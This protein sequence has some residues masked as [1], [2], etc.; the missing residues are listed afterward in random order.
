[1]LMNYFLPYEKL[2]PLFAALK[3][4]GYDCIAPQ[5]RDG[6]IVYDEII[7][8]K[9]LP[10]GMRDIQQPGSYQLEA[11]GTE[12]AFAWA[13]G[14][15][16]LKPLTFK[17]KESLWEV[18]R[19][20]NGKLTFKPAQVQA[21]PTAIFGA[22]ACDLA[23][24]A[25]QSKTFID[26]KYQDKRFIVHKNA[27]FII[28]VNCGYASSNCFC[29]STNTGPKATQGYDLAFTEVEQGFLVEIATDKGK[30]V[31]DA[32]SLSEAEKKHE[33][34][35][36]NKTKQATDMQ[37]KQMPKNNSRA[38]RDILMDNL[39]HPQWDKV[40]ERCLSCGNCTMVCPTCFCHH[41][42]E[43]ASIDGTHSEH[44]REW[45]SCFSSGHSYIHGKVIREDTRTRYRQWL[46]HK[47]GS[48]WDQFDT[49]GCVGCGR[50]VTWCP[51]G[52]DITEEMAIIADDTNKV[53]KP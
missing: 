40:A 38:L 9:Q 49:S 24:L 11:T 27:L 30:Q 5:V 33:Q 29:V 43:S 53:K 20:T 19:D 16:A 25:V 22:R 41:E 39:N 7:D 46:T 50:C 13:N 44:A 32:L 37:T 45:D 52:I 15:Q 26:N 42:T 4:Q 47:L 36:I 28:A 48:W 14:A 18:T 31:I 35:A 51:V 10:W 3:T 1:M 6:T 2:N 12:E 17:P 34:Q 8:A 21:K 23:G